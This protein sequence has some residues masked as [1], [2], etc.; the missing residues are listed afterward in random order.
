MSSSSYLRSINLEYDAEEPHRFEHFH[1]TSKSAEL[2]ASVLRQGPN[3]DAAL[4]VVAPYGSGKSLT[5]GFLLHLI[6]NEPERFPGTHDLLEL[7][8]ERIRSVRPE[9]AAQV[10]SRIAAVDRHGVVATIHG[11]HEKTLDGI[12]MGIL[13]GFR[14][15]GLGREARTIEAIRTESP[16]A[17]KEV[18]GTACSKLVQ[19][20]RDHLLI[21]WDEFGRHL[22]GLVED[23]LT[24]DLLDLQTVA[25]A[26]SRSSDVK[27][28]LLLLLHRSLAGYSVGLPSATR[29]EWSKVEGRFRTVQFVD[30]SLE[31]YR[32]LASVVTEQRTDFVPP[33]LTDL[34]EA[35]GRSALFEDVEDRRELLA[36]AYPFEPATLWLLPR[37][38]ARVAQNERT[39]F[40]LIAEADLSSPISPSFL[41]DYF[42]GEFRADT[43]PGGTHKAWLEAE[44]ALSKVPEGSLASELIKT[45]FL[46]NLG[47]G[48]ERTRATR[49][50]VAAATAGLRYA[51]S[52]VKKQLEDLLRRKLLIFREHSDHVLVWHGTDVDLRGRLRDERAQINKSFQLVPFLQQ[53]MPLPV[54]RPTRHNADTGIPRFLSAR[55]VT[56]AG[57]EQH[58]GDITM[59]LR[60]PG[61]DG[62]VLYVVPSDDEG[63]QEAQ[64]RAE[65]TGDPR[66][67]IAVSEPTR[68]VRESALELAALLRMQ[69]D[70]DL[71]NQDPLIRTELD[72][73]A[74]DVRARFAGPVRRIIEPGSA[75]VHWY[76]KGE[77]RRFPSGVALRRYLSVQM[78]EVFHASPRI[79]SE[80]IVRK[81]PTPVIVNARKKVVLGILERDG[82]PSL[83]IEGEFADKALF[84]AVLLNT[85]LFRDEPQPH[86]IMPEDV[87]DDGLRR[88]WGVLRAFVTE[89]K[90]DIALQALVHELKEPPFGV[91]EGVLPILFAA[92]LKAFPSTHAIRGRS[93]YLSDIMPSDV[94][95][96]IREPADYFIT[97]LG[98]DEDEIAYLRRLLE[99]FSAT[100]IA[101][102]DESADL[103]RSVYD[104]IQIWW[105]DLPDAAKTS[106]RLSN[107]AS[108]VRTALTT[109]DPA[110]ALLT[111]LPDAF[112]GEKRDL[113]TTLGEVIAA[114]REL[115]AIHETFVSEAGLALGAALTGRGFD[116][117]QG[118]LSAAQAWAELFPIEPP[119]PGLNALE[120]GFISQL[121][122]S[123]DDDKS[124]LAVLAILITGEPFRTWDDSTVP[125]FQRK[126]KNMVDGIESAALDALSKGAD[127]R[128]E[129]RTGMVRLATA[130]IRK[131]AAE[132]E[133]LG[134]AKEL[135]HV[136][137]QLVST[138]TVA[139]PNASKEG[140]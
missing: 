138:E 35:A 88:V 78:D 63:F 99:E 47:L 89:P 52:D 126:L 11:R 55:W 67:V 24:G 22:Q 107:R 68:D 59:G 137:K 66:I 8:G 15:V 133:A 108:T 17:A 37:V 23:G 6:Q 134:G 56:P 77:V 19:T 57:L 44:S 124:L 95:E 85:G 9:L 2:I 27:V 1:P 25:E 109:A 4:L 123:H 105:R 30:D 80:M 119:I 101:N 103:I 61:T 132:L 73:L 60:E 65:E 62:E 140:E 74:D 32:L 117:E 128:P 54:W 39:A 38:A 113:D 130:R 18:V 41:Y 122:R 94:E 116:T 45:T 115:Q 50:S 86:F 29:R 26:A 83:G 64:T 31:A 92:A 46:L 70:A 110:D 71:I 43:G 51:P 114:K 129:L 34:L 36:S 72:Q 49:E 120:R 104:A 58:L 28:T 112:G 127:G 10:R 91:R 69:R 13:D 93:G 53:E 135:R 131:A 14:R 81:R 16:N 48:G 96:M 42:R 12:K 82:K 76:H 90:Q 106:R 87:E 79:R 20:G 40:S 5:A 118:L 3:D 97:V 136:L 139:A 111:I 100:I 7:V 21:I 98:L 125:D 84:R 102:D 121:R 33:P 75:W